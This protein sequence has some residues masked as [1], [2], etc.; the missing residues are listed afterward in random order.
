MRASPH[1]PPCIREGGIIS[2]HTGSLWCAEQ[3]THHTHTARS[4]GLYVRPLRALY[5]TQLDRV[6][7]NTELKLYTQLTLD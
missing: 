7:R 6:D 4:G 2:G 3:R 5:T 1:F